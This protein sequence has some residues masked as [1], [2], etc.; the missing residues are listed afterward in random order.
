MA[1][2]ELAKTAFPRPAL[3]QILAAICCACAGASALATPTTTVALDSASGCESGRLRVATAGISGGR[4]YWR[5]TWSDTMS[6]DVLLGE[7][8]TAGPADGYVGSIDF[9]FVAGPVPFGI[10]VTLYGYEG[11]TPPTPATTS[12]F[13]LTYVC[14]SLEVLSS[15]AGPYG[16]ITPLATANYE[17][18]W[19]KSP[20]ASESGWGIN[21]AHQGDV[22][23]ATWFTYDASGKAWWLSMTATKSTDAT[24]TGTLYQTRGPAFNAVPFDNAAVSRDAVGTGTLTFADANNAE[25]AFTVNG[26]SLTKTIT[27]QVFGPLPTCVFAAGSD[28]ALATN[29]QDLWFAAPAG[30]ESGWGMNL[31]HQG[32][33]IF[34][35]W[36][37]YDAAGLPLWLSATATKTGA[38]QYAGAL[39]LTT[40]PAFDATVFAP[41]V[42]RAGVGTM[43]LDFANGNTASFAYTLALDGAASRVTQT[44]Q[45]TRQV[46]RSPGTICH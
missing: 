29:Y 45:I 1:V 14:D 6:K 5:A 23:F 10:A 40:G 25:F 46:F 33:I 19:W 34:A 31:T 43:S 8:E 28:L 11:T 37:T 35:T 30:S 38:T 4:Q 21:L 17:G 18:L 32:D 22:I 2:V 16:T 13:S 42:G 24:Y 41:P 44:R 20:A 15:R 39:F 9:P 7:G 26:T 3:L 27:R 12:E 36:F